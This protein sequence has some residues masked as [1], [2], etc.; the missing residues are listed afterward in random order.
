MLDVLS[1]FN[2]ARSYA[3]EHPGSEKLSCCSLISIHAR[4]ASMMYRSSETLRNVLR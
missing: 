3:L 4:K 1:R 2:P